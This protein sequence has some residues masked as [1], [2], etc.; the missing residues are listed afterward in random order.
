MLRGTCAKVNDTAA[1]PAGRLKVCVVVLGVGRKARAPQKNMLCFI[2]RCNCGWGFFRPSLLTALSKATVKGD[3][4]AVL[5][6]SLQ[7]QV[8]ALVLGGPG[9]PMQQSIAAKS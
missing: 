2:K 5:V 8:S 9:A 1:N 3:S 4:Y 6:S 7:A